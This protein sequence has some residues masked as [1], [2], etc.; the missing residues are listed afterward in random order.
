M[1]KVDA[2]LSTAVALNTLSAQ[3]SLKS[4]TKA[5]KLSTDSWKINETQLKSAGKY[6]EAAKA[7]YDGLGRTISLQQSKIDSLR[8]KQS[9]LNQQDDKDAA[10]IVKL[11]AE[12]AKEETR[13]G[14]LQGQYERSAKTVKYYESGLADLQETYR[15]N[16]RLSKSTIDRLE[17]EGKTRAAN[18]E[19]IRSED[20]SLSNLT[21]QYKK[22]VSELKQLEATEG[23]FSSAVKNQKVRVNETATAM[24]TARTK[25]DEL[26]KSGKVSHKLFGATFL[27]NLGANVAIS[28]ITAVKNATVGLIKT[29]MEYNKEQDRMRGVWHSLTEE[30]PKDGKA[31]VGFINDISSKSMYA[32]DTVNEMAQSFYHVHSSRE[33]TEKWTKSFVALG[34]T[35]QMSNAKLAD[36]G[37]MFGKIVAGGKASAEDLNVMI[38]RFPMWGEAMEK[39]TGKSMKQLRAMSAA[40][41][42]TSAQFTKTLDYLGKKYKNGTANAL[43]TYS[44][45]SS[46]LQ[47][48]FQKLSGDVTKNGFNVSKSTLSAIRQVTNDKSMDMYSKA[49]SAAFSG[50]VKIVAGTLR[51][52]VA[53]RKIIMNTIGGLLDIAGA[54]GKIG[55]AIGKNLGAQ[56][57]AVLKPLT[58]FINSLTGGDKGKG[59]AETIAGILN[60]IAKNKL[61]VTAVSDAILGIAGFKMAKKTISFGATVVD[62]TKDG[63]VKVVSSLGKMKARGAKLVSFAAKVKD[64]T[65]KTLTAIGSR[66]GKMA[67]A[68]GRA[69]IWTAKILYSGA[70]KSA[71]LL[72][73]ATMATGRGIG[74]ALRFTAKVST[75][76]A[77]LALKGLRATALMTGK[78][79]KTAFNFFKANPLVAVISVVVAL[80]VALVELYKHNKKFR[81]FVNGIVSACKSMAKRALK[82][83]KSMMK[84]MK[85]VFSS[86]FKV[87]KNYVAVFADVFTGKWSRV[88]KDVKKLIASMWKFVKDVFRSGFKVINTLTGGRLGKMVKVFKAAGGAIGKA[89]KAT[90]N[91]L[92]DFFTDV[93][94]KIKSIAQ[95]GVNGV[96]GVIRGVVGAVNGVIHMFGGKKTTI[97]K[98]AYVHLAT[99]TGYGVRRAINKVTPAI[100]NDGP[101]ADNQETILRAS[102]RVEKPKGQNVETVLL[103]GDEVLNATESKQFDQA[104]SHF[105]K[106]TGF[107]SGIGSAVSDAVSGATS[108]VANT[109]T[110]L[111]K[112]FTTAT[113][114]VANP[115]KAFNSLFSFSSKKM[116]GVIADI[117]TGLFKKTTDAG[118]DWW[119][120]LWS[121]VDLNGSASG[122]NWA[123]SPGAGWTKTSGFG[124]RGSGSG[125]QSNHDGVDFGAASGSTI[126]AVHGG[127][128]VRVGGAPG[129]WGPVGYNVVTKGDDGKYVIYQEFGTAKNTSLK[130][131]DTIKTG[132]KIG[133]L[134][135]NTVGTGEHV[136]IGVSN[137][138]PFHNSG[139]TTK[140]WFDVTKMHGSSSG[141]SKSDKKNNKGLAGLVKNQVGS[142]FWSTIKML[143]S[144]FGDDAGGSEGNPS[145]ASVN[146]WKTYVIKAL[147]ANGFSASASQVAAWLRVIKRESNGNPKA[148]NNWDSNAKAGHP[149]K[150]LVQTIDPTFK[151]YAFAG[152]KNIYNGYDNLLAAIKYASARYGRGAGMFSRVGGSQGYANGGIVSRN[153][154]AEIAEGG[155]TESIIPWDVNKRSRAYT[156]LGKTVAHFAA[157]DS[158]GNAGSGGGA[159]VDNSEVV[160]MLQSTNELLN[161]L[162]STVAN[163]PVLSNNDVYNATQAVAAKKTKISNYA[164]GRFGL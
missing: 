76:A 53:N 120:Q 101:E 144:K 132:S 47:S 11:T 96:I 94:K 112:M 100:V 57:M 150:G 29:G 44:G 162:I 32:S 127:T 89:W 98:P 156:L 158:T 56:A 66:I 34:S 35:L 111:K 1:A 81:K 139:S 84:S 123:H 117:G 67:K 161:A 103:P 160:Q 159:Y 24:A 10:A 22:Q 78:G 73:R 142:G 151:A 136:H 2:Q 110:N 155:K 54:I 164:K 13:L 83:V 30:A 143:A 18:R 58:H 153:Q 140:G 65:G 16:Q 72:G 146:R 108:W 102:G 70:V 97:S 119:N 4:L 124:Y 74:R 99:G 3:N 129:G 114:I 59:V 42:L 79:I 148:I 131:G 107:W 113:K 126:H 36:S 28:G 14:S 8:K 157:T 86:G 87:I 130:V 118:K 43:Q 69:L 60:G 116:P 154:I 31:L 163:K 152:H 37:E 125:G 138:Y 26:N 27:G 21:Q 122:G 71:K 68:M 134:G 7:K 82:P 19:R 133:T 115:T 121:M 141:S 80:S 38:D 25:T 95:G 50:T 45:M 33:E 109:V 106:G 51:T 49:I 6:V 62:K 75:K 39:A 147:K 52:I 5:V 105:A 46:Y 40:G 12:I 92:K 77:I 15:E 149:S 135:R 128:V 88:G 17:A 137:N 48:R 55:I 41:T 90:F 63:W 93:W 145:G 23:K 9:E 91:G 85:K 61:A 104:R 20:Q 64:L